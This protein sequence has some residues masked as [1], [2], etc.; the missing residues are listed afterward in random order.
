MNV[1]MIM[2][3]WFREIINAN[4]YPTMQASISY[5]GKNTKHKIYALNKLFIA[6]YSIIRYRQY[7]AQEI[8]RTY[9]FCI[10]ET[11]YPLNNFPFPFLNRTG[12]QIFLS[13]SINLTLLNTSYKWKSCN[14]C[15][16]VTSLF[17]WYNFFKVYSP[18][19]I[20]QCFLYLMWNNIPL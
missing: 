7:V 16:F 10:I 17:L 14:I 5:C 11:L 8:P 3:W 9:S 19:C 1:T 13:A 4:L 6:Q 18:C 2:K 12:N 20:W 15:P